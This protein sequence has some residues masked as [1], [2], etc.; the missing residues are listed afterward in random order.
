MRRHKNAGICNASALNS[1][2][3][4]RSYAEPYAHK[5]GTQFAKKYGHKALHKAFLNPNALCALC[6]S[7]VFCVK[8]YASLMRKSFRLLFQHN[9][10]V[11]LI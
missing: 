5:A 1:C 11:V 7:W 3:D 9:T 2:S 10:V 4:W 6:A 8:P